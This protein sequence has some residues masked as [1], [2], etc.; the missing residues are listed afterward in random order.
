MRPVETAVGFWADRHAPASFVS[1]AAKLIEASGVVDGL[2]IPD[3][4]VN[5]MPASLWKP[6]HVPLA[7]FM[8]DPDSLWDAFT[9]AAY[10]MAAAPSLDLTI[11]TDA[12]RNNPGELWQRLL[13]LSCI[14]EGR[15]SLH[16]GG[17]EAKNIQPFGLKRAE[18]IKRMEDMFQ[19]WNLLWKSKGP[20]DFK[21]HFWNLER[22][23]VGGVKQYRPKFGGLGEAPKILDLSTSYGDSVAWAA[24]LKDARPEDC[25]IR[26]TSIKEDLKR[27]GRDPS[28]FQIGIHAI[29]LMHDDPAVLES[30]LDNKLVRYMAGMFGRVDADNW[31]REGLKSPVPEG[32]RY[33]QKFLPYGT[34]AEFVD[35]VAANTTRDHVLK[36]FFCGTPAQ[37]GKRLREYVEVGVDWVGILDYM[38][39]ILKPELA[40]VAINNSIECSRVLKS[41][42][43]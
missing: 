27:K 40:A 5:I 23:F 6:E 11:L 3:H 41:G 12:V 24:P 21:G 34:S 10:S 7:A 26:V 8:S 2:L 33:Y 18:G 16:L 1:Q 39:V 35:E 13:A 19:I 36:G 32:W 37:V 42:A 15:T 29:V 28:K 9:T 30:A 4:M 43:V 17:G 22:A 14:T 25:A 38:P 20:V 31:A